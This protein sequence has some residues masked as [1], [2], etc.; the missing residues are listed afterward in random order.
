MYG[1]FKPRPLEDESNVDQRR[2]EVGLPSLAEYLKEAESF[3][4]RDGS[5]E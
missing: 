5:K 4:T 2:K 3:Y 1:K